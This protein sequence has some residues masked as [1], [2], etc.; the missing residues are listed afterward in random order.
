MLP[1]KIENR[2]LCKATDIYLFKVN[3]GNTRTMCKI[4]SKL[5]LITPD[6]RHWRRFVVFI[7][8]F[9]QISHIVLTCSL[10]TLNKL[11]SAGVMTSFPLETNLVI[12]TEKPVNF[13]PQ[14]ISIIFV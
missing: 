11:I 9:E 1:T 7:V 2:S 10:L 13:E 12:K 6:L 8:N 4:C 14:K 5:T 3:N